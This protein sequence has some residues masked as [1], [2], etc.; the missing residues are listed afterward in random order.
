MS[1]YTA[2]ES[3]QGVVYRLKKPSNLRI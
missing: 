3:V 1:I 2:P